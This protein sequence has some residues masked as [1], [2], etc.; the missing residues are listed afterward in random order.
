MPPRLGHK[1]SRRGCLMCKQRRVKT[2]SQ[3]EITQQDDTLTSL[4]ASPD[5]LPY[6]AKFVRGQEP[7]EQTT[8][9]TDLELMHHHSTCTYLTLP[10]ADELQHIWQIEMPKLAL[11]HV[12]LLHQ[13]LS[14]SAYHLAHLNPDRPG[15]PVCA[16]QHQNEAIKG[17]RSA[18]ES[19]SQDNCV[20]IFLASSL[21]SIG[22][23]AGF[24]TQSS[25]QQPSI[26]DLLD[27]FVLIRGMSDILNKY[28]T[29]LNQILEQRTIQIHVSP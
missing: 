18:I 21:L 29:T 12:Y 1:K 14:V 24:S 26:D 9:L 6:L 10:R 28:Q 27:V 7:I 25:G 11:R 3:G 19:I 17:L 20:E 13:V 4:A 16:S 15:F 5:P 2:R 8:W 22:A 23:F